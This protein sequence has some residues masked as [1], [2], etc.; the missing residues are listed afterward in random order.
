MP[1]YTPKYYR[2]R[3]PFPE[4]SVRYLF[5]KIDF[6]SIDGSHEPRIGPVSTKGQL[7]IDFVSA[8]SWT[9]FDTIWAA[10]T[11]SGAF[12]HRLGGHALAPTS[13][14]CEPSVLG[15][16]DSGGGRGVIENHIMKHVSFPSALE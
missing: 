12:V 4:I 3:F 1:G 15:R 2:D 11:E 5:G 8:C 16:T 10:Q 6:C 14:N 9:Q 7:G 13:S